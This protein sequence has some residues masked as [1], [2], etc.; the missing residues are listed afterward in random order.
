ME[1]ILTDKEKIDSWID[2]VE[3]NELYHPPFNFRQTVQN[4]LNS[5]NIKFTNTGSVIMGA[6][7]LVVIN[8][9]EG[10]KKLFGKMTDQELAPTVVSML[11]GIIHFT[12]I[13]TCYCGWLKIIEIFNSRFNY[14]IP[15]KIIPRYISEDTFN[16]TK[17][18]S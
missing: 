10:V 3:Y 17:E 13:R 6:P 15:K 8:E 14:S 4:I 18:F 1:H 16:I 9:V 12:D 7:P 2:L 11:V 5:M